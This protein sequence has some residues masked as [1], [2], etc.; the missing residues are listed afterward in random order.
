M[1]TTETLVYAGFWWRLL[2]SAIDQMLITIAL[3]PIL[4]IVYGGVSLDPAAIGQ[5]PAG[6]LLSVVVPAIIVLV[7]WAARSATPGKMVI[8]A[9]IVRAD[10]GERP[11]TGQF[12]V[13]YLGYYLSC[14]PLGLGFVWIAFDPRKQG[15]HDMLA[16]T[17]VTRKVT[18][19]PAVRFEPPG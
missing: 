6:L 5:G 3:V 16:G 12:V 15:W 10:T 8:A 14:L 9:R 4:V 7:F 18:S 17:V 1:E 2:A 13:R 19:G 11:I